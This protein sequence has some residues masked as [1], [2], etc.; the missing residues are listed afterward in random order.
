MKRKTLLRQIPFAVRGRRKINGLRDE[1]A[2]RKALS[3]LATV[4]GGQGAAVKAALTSLQ[5]KLPPAADEWRER[6][7]AERAR[8]LG[9]VELVDDGSL[10]D[11]GPYDK[12]VT[13]QQACFVSKPQEQAL[14]LFS[15]ARAARPANVLEV[16]TNVGISSAYIGA[17]LKLNGDSGE[18]T[19]LDASRYRQRLAKEAHRNLGIDNV[20]YVE[21]LFTKTLRPSLERLRSVDLAFIDGHHQYQPTLDYFEKIMA[22][23]NAG[24]VLVFD[25]I[26]WSKGMKQAWS[27]IAR[28]K[29]VAV[30]VDLQSVGVCVVGTG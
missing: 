24:S 30:A 2:K 20:S 8:L 22:F 1:R 23:S 15:L 9:R 16:G 4:P 3:Q 6:I 18:L 29:R 21:G 27:R 26:R 19:T 25:D 17:A 11:G 28:D 12:G 7:E 10:R 13:I 14:L 5:R